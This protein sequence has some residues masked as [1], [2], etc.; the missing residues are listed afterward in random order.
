M[1]TYLLV[2]SVALSACGTTSTLTKSDRDIQAKLSRHDSSCKSITRVYSGVAYDICRLNTLP[3]SSFYNPFLVV[4]LLD[5]PVSALFDTVALPYTLV[6][7]SQ[8]GNIDVS[9]SSH[10]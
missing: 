10:R 2:L 5:A 1:K 6:R 3:N 9:N 8:D 4:Y 7:Q